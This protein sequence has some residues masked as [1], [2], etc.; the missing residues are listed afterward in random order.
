[1][2]SQ[3]TPRRECPICRK[4]PTRSSAGVC[5][6]CKPHPSVHRSGEVIYVS[7]LGALSHAAALRLAW[8][9]CDAATP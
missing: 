1:M 7:G 2:G 8:A 5:F 6:R 9:I 4:H 3:P